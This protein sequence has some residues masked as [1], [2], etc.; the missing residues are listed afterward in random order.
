MEEDRAPGGRLF[1]AD[2]G[3]LADLA[4]ACG[5]TLGLARIDRGERFFLRV[6]DDGEYLG[7]VRFAP[8]GSLDY[9]ASLLFET[10]TARGV[11]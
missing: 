11:V 6:W 2:F 7:G 4:D 1:E 9:A 5:W 8:D 3:Y 10:L